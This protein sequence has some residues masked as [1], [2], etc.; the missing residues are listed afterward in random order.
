MTKLKLPRKSTNIDMTAMCDVAFLLLTFFML[1]TKFKP[2]DPVEIKTPSSV[3]AKVIPEKDVLTLSFDKEGKVYLQMDNPM[4]KQKTI[5]DI[6]NDMG[7]GL[8]ASQVKT[9]VN[10]A[11]L[12]VPLAKLSSFLSMDPEDSKKV[13]QEG[14]P[15]D[16]LNNE[17]DIWVRYILASYLGH[18][19]NIVVKGD[20]DANYKNFKSVV[21]ALK[22]NE[23]FK[24]ELITA[25]E[26]AP[27]GTAL[28]NK[29]NLADK[30]AG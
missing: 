6:S 24:F 23:Q 15:V 10:S 28:W 4:Y 19:L 20:N 2:D 1:A 27:V 21:D 16:S 30:K 5:E 13:V 8:N 9:F 11:S 18:K 22:K 17:L 7:L 12:G 25:P 26:D 3:A 14:I 29:R